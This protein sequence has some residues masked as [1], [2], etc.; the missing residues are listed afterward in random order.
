MH[1]YFLLSLV[2]LLVL[3]SITNA[4]IINI[5]TDYPTI[6]DGIDNAV[7]FDTLSIAGGSYTENLTVNGKS[8]FFI[9]AGRDVTFLTPS[10]P[11]ASTIYVLNVSD[12]VLFQGFTVSGGGSTYTFRIS[13]VADIVIRDNTF[14]DNIPI[15]GNNI[16]VISCSSTKAYITRNVFYNNGG[17][18]CVGLRSGANNSLIINNTFDGNER[19]LFSISGGG[20]VLNNIISNSL[21]Y[22]IVG[23]ASDFTT[24]DY[25]DVWNNNVNYW[26]GVSAG[27]YDISTDPLYMD[28][29]THDYQ[30][31][32]GSPCIDAGDPDVAYIDPDGSRNDMGA[33]Y[34][35]RLYPIPANL[36]IYQN[37]LSSVVD[38]IPTFI[39][40]YLDNTST[41]QTMYEVEVGT[42]ADWTVAEMWAS[43]EVASSDTFAVYSGL[44]LIDGTTYFLRVRVNNGTDWGDWVNKS[45]HMNS[46]PSVPALIHPINS[47]AIHYLY[48]RLGIDNAIDADSNPLTYDFEVY[49]DEF[50]TS[51]LDSKYDVAEQSLITQTSFIVGLNPDQQYWWR[52]RSFDG[53]EYS[54]WSSPETFMT[55]SGTVIYV[56]DDFLSIQD[57]IDNIPDGDTIMVGPGTYQENLVLSGKRIT[58]T[59]SGRDLTIL[60]PAIANDPLLILQNIQDSIMFSGFTVT[61]GGSNNTIFISNV[62]DVIIKDNTF[63]DNIPIGGNNIEVISCSG[64]NAY[65]TRNLF[66]NN[67]GIGCVGLLGGSSLSRII[68]NTFDGNER[69]LVSIAGGGIVIN[70][71]VSNS[72]DYGINGGSSDFTQLDYNDVWNNNVD[73]GFGASAG[74][75]DISADPLYFDAVSH[76]YH[77]DV[78]SPCIDAGNPDIE[79]NDPDGSRNDMGAFYPLLSPPLPINLSID[80]NSL[81]NV[82]DN[83]PTFIW[84]YYDDAST[85]QTMYEVEV[86]TDLDWTVAE[87]WTSGVV[88]SADTFA[89][90]NGSELIDGTTYYVRARVNNGTYWG[91]WLVKAFHTNSIPSVPVLVF[92]INSQLVHYL[93]TRLEVNNSTDPDSSPLTYDF[94]VYSDELLTSLVASE[95]DVAEQSPTTMTDIIAGL[96][97]DQQYWWHCRSFD[98]LEY[99]DW[100]VAGT[101]ITRGSGV[102]YV[103]DDFSTIQDAI[104]NAPSGD[105]VMVAA[106]SYQENLT[107]TGKRINLIGA[108][109]E[110]TILMP[111]IGTSI[112]N[113]TSVSDSVIFSGFTVTGGGST[114]TIYINSVDNVVIR[115]NIFYDDI[116]VGGNN[117][118]VI[119]CNNTNAYITRNLFYNNGGIGCVGLRSGAGSSRIINNTFDGNER[120]LFSIAGGGVVINNIVTNS[121]AYG[122]DGSSSDFTQLDYNDVWNNN[123]NYGFGAS[124]GPNDISDDPLYVDAP[125]RDY[126]LVLESPCINAG[127][128]DPAYNDWDGSRNDMGAYPVIVD[129]PYPF[130]LTVAGENDL[131]VVNHNPTFAWQYIDS[132]VTLQ[133]SFEIEVGSD[134][135][136]TVAELWSTGE[137]VSS[138]TFVVYN[139]NPLLD[140]NEYFCRCRV[141]NGTK[142]GGWV[143]KN[144]RMNSLPTVPNLLFPNNI[145]LYYSDIN[146]TAEHATDP[147]NDSL[148]YDFE[149]YADESLSNL[150]LEFIDVPDQPDSI[151]VHISS[152]LDPDNSYWWRARSYDGYEFS[153]WSGSFTFSTRNNIT[154]YIPQDYP[155]IQE[156]INVASDLDTILVSPGEYVENIDFYGKSLI[157]KSSYGPDSTTIKSLLGGDAVVKFVSGE[158]TNTLLSGFT[159]IPDLSDYG[160]Q[161]SNNASPYITNNK[162]YGFPGSTPVIFADNA[163]AIIQRNLFY[164]NLSYCVYINSG[165]TEIKNN[166]FD[167]NNDIIYA[168]G[169]SAIVAN[170]IIAHSTGTALIGGE[171]MSNDYND[172]YA[173]AINYDNVTPGSHSIY[174][175]PQFLDA[176]NALYYL[177]VT[178]PCIDAGNP[179]IYYNDPDGSI[180]D[181]GAFY[182][183]LSPINPPFLIS[184]PVSIHTPV[185]DLLPEFSWRVI[186]ALESWD[187]LTYTLT[188]GLDSQFVFSSTV[189]NITDTTYTLLD[190]LQFNTKYWWKIQART[191][192]GRTSES[193]I[194]SFTTWT[195]GDMDGS[196]TVDIGDLVYMVDFMFN[197]GSP[198]D[199]LFIGDVN[200]DC[201]FDIADLVYFVNY[202]FSDGPDLLPGCP[203]TKLDAAGTKIV[204][205]IKQIEPKSTQES[206]HRPKSS[207][208][209]LK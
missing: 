51:L 126:N 199:P 4:T 16:E 134:T 98:G 187:Y 188:I 38:Q 44:D 138:D 143:Q 102:I 74:P 128:P 62:A 169:A 166:T 103:P 31:D 144:F 119:S 133:Y 147:E 28:E 3:C 191:R 43:G 90:Y 105:T 194:N 197:N 84:E 158:N 132:A 130:D 14:H 173:N 70:N 34:K 153:D 10:N 142:W 180:N 152:G 195:I 41:T 58:L 50:L 80:Q 174:V 182:T 17:I 68:N 101:F 88:A 22:G 60:T 123:V 45:F 29:A 39:W 196:N 13:N 53:Y 1:K 111:A 93:Y 156:G 56:P 19:G 79:Y 75:N 145:Q 115:D 11:S 52:C 136:W 82:V 65:V 94:E 113:I 154:I 120:G 149:V 67:G 121:L 85:M 162:F 54:D 157:V 206:V 177:L 189:P 6:Q 122:I 20:I 24:L 59:G 99:S 15:G 87:M 23:S 42:D 92:P 40:L 140:G 37:S 33:F 73:Y 2:F 201:M 71:I 171:S 78:G 91:D 9:G 203:D 165:I 124:A 186:T 36:S 12:S 26:N 106:G 81:T 160:I 131:N 48:T 35:Y 159:I 209:K 57:A 125:N 183:S 5:P 107:I 164:E 146:L 89:V 150:V 161:L 141:F 100:S 179:S 72:L 208:K 175:D 184:P 25:N 49:S 178:S 148:S 69:G 129:Y 168:V 30:L 205:T 151:I 77:L 118:E 167:M 76:D 104:N 96:D 163:H 170:N 27:T 61:G 63:R 176:G 112:L 109:A 202:M 46:I 127:D 95:Y 135:D 18:G 139:G 185:Y 198:I 200:Q 97:P 181:I 66:Y 116:P 155:T 8:I 83:T 114:Y 55:R 204:P 190:S 21:D 86:G 117:I 192:V 137:V 32:V 172:L 108:G 193:F 7:N 47:Q 64:T 207:I 110:S